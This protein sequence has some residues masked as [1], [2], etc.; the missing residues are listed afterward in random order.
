MVMW[1]KVGWFGIWLPIFLLWPIA[2]L[3]LLIFLPLVFIG[4]AIT[5]QLPRFWRVVRVVLAL[6]TMI[7]AFRGLRIEIHND[8]GT[9]EVYLP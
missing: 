8:S 6:Y 1:L 7:C 4:M 9:F 2:L 3:L 5:G